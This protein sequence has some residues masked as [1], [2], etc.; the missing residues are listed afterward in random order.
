[1]IR[2]TSPTRDRD[3]TDREACSDRRPS[4][5]ATSAA[6]LCPRCRGDADA[7]AGR[8]AYAGFIVADWKHNSSN[9]WTVPLGATYS[10]LTKP[11]GFV[12]VNYIMG[13]GY[14]VVRPDLAG[15][16]FFRFQVNFVLPK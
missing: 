3:A 5:G 6:W 16:W 13:G 9:R 2:E 4:R 1:M 11:A 10:I 14:N 12:P 8:I 7:A 15:N